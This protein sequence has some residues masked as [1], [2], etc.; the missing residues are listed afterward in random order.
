MGNDTDYDTGYGFENIY[1][2][3]VGLRVKAGYGNEGP[4]KM[5]F[6]TYGLGCYR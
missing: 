5:L 2:Y 4:A 6:A 3:M 1:L